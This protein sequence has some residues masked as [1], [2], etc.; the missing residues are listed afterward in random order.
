[1]VST[2]VLVMVLSRNNQHTPAVANVPGY[3]TYSECSTAADKLRKE[4]NGVSFNFAET[5]CVEVK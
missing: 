3:S 2:F 5:F 4:V 1:M